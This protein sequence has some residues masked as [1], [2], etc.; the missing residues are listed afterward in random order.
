MRRSRGL[1]ARSMDARVK[2]AH[3][4]WKSNSVR[5]GFFSNRRSAPQYFLNPT[6]SWNFSSLALRLLSENISS[7]INGLVDY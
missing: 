3:D 1:P 2:P 5:T 6:N 7:Y 4:E